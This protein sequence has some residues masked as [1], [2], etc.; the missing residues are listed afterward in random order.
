MT[1]DPGWRKRMRKNNPDAL[2]ELNMRYYHS[3]AGQASRQRT[4]ER[5][6]AV[7]A[8]EKLRRGSACEDCK[9]GRD[10]V[11]HH[12][13]PSTKRFTLGYSIIK[14]YAAIREELA[15]C[16]LLCPNCHARRHRQMREAK[17]PT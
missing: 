1:N 14:S 12:R 6:R 5:K 16:D 15:K 7:V 8:A 17:C 3:E 11:W 13:D 2:R 9:Y 10:L 4:H